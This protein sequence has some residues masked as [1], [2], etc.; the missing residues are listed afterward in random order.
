MKEQERTDQKKTD[1]KNTTTLQ[2]KCM[3]GFF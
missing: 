3:S 1:T 2:P